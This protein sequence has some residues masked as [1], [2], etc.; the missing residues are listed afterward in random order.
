MLPRF[1]VMSGHVRFP[2]PYSVVRAERPPDP[3]EMLNL[4]DGRPSAS[5]CQSAFRAVRPELRFIPSLSSGT[6]ALEN[7][8]LIM[9]L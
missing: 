1:R 3:G 5:D 7:K 4:A 6:Y 9:T 8:C 2:S